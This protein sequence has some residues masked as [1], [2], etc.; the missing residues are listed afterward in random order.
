M[1]MR[2]VPP[3]VMKDAANVLDNFLF[4]M[5]MAPHY[6]TCFWCSVVAT[7]TTLVYSAP[8]MKHVDESF[9]PFLFFFLLPNV[10]VFSMCCRDSTLQKSY[11]GWGTL[12]LLCQFGNFSVIFR[13]CPA[14]ISR[15]I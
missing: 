10:E 13:M 4:I 3:T 6:S 15:N 9:L 1:E 11:G 12:N 14:G 2:K 7:R 5:A 8:A